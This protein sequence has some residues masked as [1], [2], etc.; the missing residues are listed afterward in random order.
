MDTPFSAPCDL[1]VLVVPSGKTLVIVQPIPQSAAFAGVTVTL[2]LRLMASLLARPRLENNSKLAFFTRWLWVSDW[3]LG[4]A[5]LAR[6][7]N[8]AT[9]ISSSVRVKPEEGRLVFIWSLPLAG[10][11]AVFGAVTG[12]GQPAIIRLLAAGRGG[13]NGEGRRSVRYDRATLGITNT[14]ST[15]DYNTV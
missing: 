14:I 7:P 4:K 1:T 13:G 11:L 10:I 2:L 3:K 6:M 8:I 15:S 5:M 12:Q 9:T